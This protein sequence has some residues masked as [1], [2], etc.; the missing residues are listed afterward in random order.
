MGARTAAKLAVK[1]TTMLS[2]KYRVLSSSALKKSYLDIEHKGMGNKTKTRRIR[3]IRF[4]VSRRRREIR[5]ARGQ[6]AG[7]HK[8]RT[9]H[10]R[11]NPAREGGHAFFADHLS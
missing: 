8:H 6:L 2:S 11:P 4:L 7:V 3:M 9:E 5:H 10:V 1:C